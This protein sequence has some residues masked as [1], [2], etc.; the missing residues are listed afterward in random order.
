MPLREGSMTGHIGRRDFITLLGGAAAAWP[1]AA[2]AQQATKLRRI[3]VL[4]ALAAD[5]AESSR[6][7]TAF[8]QGLQELGWA[9]GRNMRVDVR[10]GAGDAGRI[11]DYAAELVAMAPD[12]I[13]VIGAG[14]LVPLQQAT[15]TVPI[16]FALVS[17]PVGAGFV[18]SLAR[19]GG[20]VTGFGFFEFSTGGKWVELLK[21]VA[22]GVTRMAVIRDP[23][24][25]AGVGYLTAIRSLA[26]LRGVEVS[27]ID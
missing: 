9:E 18:E 20:N 4:Q 6:R 12:V 26:P 24:Q 2:R 16:V 22:P 1:L 7:F 17:D 21:E 27:V 13:F 15:R 10:W 11:R 8:V 14:S 23:T 19:P 25:P 3:G 5:D